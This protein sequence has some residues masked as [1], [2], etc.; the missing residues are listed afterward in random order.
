MEHLVPAVAAAVGPQRIVLGGRAAPRSTLIQEL[1]TSLVLLY[2][3]P[4]WSCSTNLGF[5]S[6]TPPPTE[7]IEAT[8]PPSFLPGFAY[9]CVPP[10][11]PM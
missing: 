8:T 4:P 11:V 3:S 6:L 10:A 7:D 5:S 1:G 9:G 2:T